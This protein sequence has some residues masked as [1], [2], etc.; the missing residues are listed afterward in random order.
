M[1]TRGTTSGLARNENELR[2]LGTAGTGATDDSGL[3][4]YQGGLNGGGVVTGPP[5]VYVV[6]WG[7]QWGTETTTQLRGELPVLQRRPRRRRA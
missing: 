6:F 5:R 1:P 2:G 3:L 4:S 7:T